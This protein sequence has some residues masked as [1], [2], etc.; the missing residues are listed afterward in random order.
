MRRAIIPFV[1]FALVAAACGAGS[2]GTRNRRV[3]ASALD[4]V[5]DSSYSFDYRETLTD[6]E[7]EIVVTGVVADDLRSR[8][9]L[10]ID[11]KKVLE[12]IVSDDAIAVRVLDQ[13]AAAPYVADV[14][15]QEKKAGDALKAGQ[16]VVDQQGAPELIAPRTS[17]NSIRVGSNPLLDATNYLFQ[18]IEDSMNAGDQR[19]GVQEFNPDGVGYNP[20]DDPWNDDAE[21]NL[22]DQGVRRYDISQP[23]LPRRTQR[24]SEGAIAST[25]HFRKMVFYLDGRDLVEVKEQIDIRD[26]LEFRRAAAGRAAN[27]YTELMEQSLA[28][29]TR[30]PIRQRQLEVSFERE[31]DISVSLPA[32]NFVSV[33]PT[34]LVSPV[35]KLVPQVQ[36]RRPALPGAPAPETSEP[37]G[38]EPAATAGADDA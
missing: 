13:K 37:D 9:T 22:V 8:A 12:Q 33:P 35:E 20:L 3:V 17:E 21:A 31:D 34:D 38:S 1:V 26:R 36:S 24:G 27:Y 14:A 28:G 16:W 10:E 6:S 18:Y 15:R 25:N 2:G 4:R 32:D 29:A 5:S 23:P 7:T 19:Q 30:E 11:G